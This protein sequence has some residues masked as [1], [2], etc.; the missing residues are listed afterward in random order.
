MIVSRGCAACAASP[1]F[2]PYL[3]SSRVK[4]RSQD[5]MQS[6]LRGGMWD[7]NVGCGRGCGGDAGP[8][9]IIISRRHPQAT[10]EDA[11]QYA[12]PTRSRPAEPQH[13]APAGECADDTRGRGA[14]EQMAN[15]CWVHDVAA[16]RVL[17]A[18]RDAPRENAQRG[19]L[20][21]GQPLDP[22]SL[23][24]AAAR[25]P[26]PTGGD[27]KISSGRYNR[28]MATMILS[29]GP[30]A[31][32]NMFVVIWSDLVWVQWQRGSHMGGDAKVLWKIQQDNGSDDPVHWAAF[33]HKHVRLI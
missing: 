7:V 9:I 1:G 6:R 10:L 19:A 20:A 23:Q 16:S 25:V 15:G 11:V 33:S 27:A 31:H 3:A 22:V 17:S 8:E 5:S 14:R 32:T 4:S 26:R 30:L 21:R 2:L 28:T 12:G 18:S 29:F 24:C 13:R